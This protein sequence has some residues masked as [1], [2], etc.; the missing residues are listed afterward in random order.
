MSDG[1]TPT[2]TP[3]Y[4]Q[5]LDAA[6]KLAREMGHSYVGVEHLF[7]AIVRDR[8]AVPTQMLARI[9]DLEHVEASV[10]EEMASDAY[11]GKP[12]ADAVWLTASELLDVLSAL[13][14]V[15]APGV[16]YGFNVVGDRAWILL[17]EP[18]NTSEAVASARAQI[19]R[20]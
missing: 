3:R 17:S 13:P 8:A 11:R 6:A 19:K 18:G 2:P 7:L 12:P 1:E 4:R 16:R 20:G 15:V 10:R 9:T 5:V 14:S